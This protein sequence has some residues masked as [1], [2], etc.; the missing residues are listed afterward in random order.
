MII[1]LI[2][3]KSKLETLLSRLGEIGQKNNRQLS[4]MFNIKKL[5][6]F[7]QLQFMRI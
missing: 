7:L 5:I 3:G 2:T 6:Y 4:I 1:E